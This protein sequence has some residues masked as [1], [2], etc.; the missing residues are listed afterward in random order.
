MTDPDFQKNFYINYHQWLDNETEA[1]DNG[2]HKNFK[3][4]ARHILYDLLNRDLSDFNPSATAPKTDGA[5][6]MEDA[7][8]HPL[9]Q[10]MKTHLK[11]N[12]F[13]PFKTDIVSTLFVY[14]HYQS[15]NNLKNT[16]LNKVAECLEWIGAEKYEQVPLYSAKD[17]KVGRTNLWVVRNHEVYRSMSKQDLARA[18][19]K[20]TS[21][22]IQTPWN[23]P[24]KKE[25]PLF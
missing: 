12:I 5:K 11:G 19:Q 9:A 23:D 6:L 7:T 13:D 3:D 2:N 20:Q 16:N 24:F 1:K 21:E 25:D 17:G 22:R 8:A 4:G 18:Y 14:Q 10:L 15:T